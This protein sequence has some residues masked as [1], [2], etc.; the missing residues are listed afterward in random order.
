VKDQSNNQ[1]SKQIRHQ[2]I[3]PH[4]ALV[5][6]PSFKYFPDWAPLNEAPNPFKRQYEQQP[7]GSSDQV[8]PA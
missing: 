2:H 7:E 5:N 3:R 6:V 1:G 4:E 8:N